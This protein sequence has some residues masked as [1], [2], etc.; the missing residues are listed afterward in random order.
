MSDTAGNAATE[1][2]RT[3]TVADTTAPVITLLGGGT[4][5]VEPQKSLP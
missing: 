1:V 2:I 3:V 5:E 4:Q